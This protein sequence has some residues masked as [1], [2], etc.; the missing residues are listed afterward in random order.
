MFKTCF[1]DINSCVCLE[2]KVKE[3]HE[4][5]NI[6]QKIDSVYTYIDGRDYNNIFGNTHRVLDSCNLLVVVSIDNHQT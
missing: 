3:F 2:K 4:E 5:I 6:C 1:K